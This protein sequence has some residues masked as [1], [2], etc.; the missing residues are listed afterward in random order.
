MP[1]TPGVD[2]S[3]ASARSFPPRR[4][5]AG[6]AT[7]QP[8][9]RIAVNPGGEHLTTSWLNQTATDTAR[10]AVCGSYGCAWPPR[11]VCLLWGPERRL[12][13]AGATQ[14]RGMSGWTT[15]VSSPDPGM[16]WIPT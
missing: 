1:E 11:P 13:R 15:L 7:F 4:P 5:R 3:A 10:E 9:A 6:D 8:P 12:G 2:L 16:R 14:T